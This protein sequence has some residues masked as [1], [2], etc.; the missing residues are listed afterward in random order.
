MIA[1]LAQPCE[2]VRPA[3]VWTVAAITKLQG[4]RNED[5]HYLR[6]ATVNGVN[7]CVLIELSYGVFI[8]IAVA[9]KKLHTL[10]DA[11]NLSFGNP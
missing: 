7:A 2:I 8:H 11:I 4:T 5:F 10:V 6:C 3:R 1:L 9:T